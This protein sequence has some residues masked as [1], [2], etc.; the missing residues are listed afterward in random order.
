MGSL[1]LTFLTVENAGF[2]ALLD[3]AF[4]GVSSNPKC[5]G[6]LAHLA[7][8]ANHGPL[9]GVGY[10]ATW[11]Y[12]QSS[13]NTKQ[14]HVTAIHQRHPHDQRSQPLRHGSIRLLAP[15][16]NI[17]ESE[18]AVDGI[19]E[20]ERLASTAASTSPPTRVFLDTL[21][22]ENG[23]VVGPLSSNFIHVY[24]GVRNAEHDAGFSLFWNLRHTQDPQQLQAKLQ[25]HI[26]RGIAST[27]ENPKSFYRRAMGV[28]AAAMLAIIQQK[29]LAAL[30]SDA[31]SRVRY[32]RERTKQHLRA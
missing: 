30:V 21:I 9:T 6:L 1:G 26:D 25:Q 22:L 14:V 5:T 27:Q 10:C 29:G 15:G 11:E 16:L 7:I 8:L 23:F 28:E 18:Y 3:K 4:P 24:N 19:T 31:K 20:V 32:G 13:P 12:P 17:E 2:Y